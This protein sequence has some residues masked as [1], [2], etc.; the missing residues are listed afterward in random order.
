[1][2][3]CVCVCW[4]VVEA[5][6]ADM[7]LHDSD[8]N[9]ESSSDGSALSRPPGEAPHFVDSKKYASYKLASLH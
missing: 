7:S 2:R 9:M 6:P 1:M 3:V 5:G 4:G 8:G